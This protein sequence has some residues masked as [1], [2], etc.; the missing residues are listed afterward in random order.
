[1]LWLPCIFWLPCKKV[2]LDLQ[3]GPVDHSKEGMLYNVVL[4]LNCA[5]TACI[6]L[7]AEAFNATASS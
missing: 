6:G 4:C 3:I 7:F 2:D 1:M 5:S